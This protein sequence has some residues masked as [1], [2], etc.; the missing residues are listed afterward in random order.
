MAQK[1][2]PL[3][4]SSETPCGRYRGR[5][6]DHDRIT[7]RLPEAAGSAGTKEPFGGRRASQHRWVRKHL[8]VGTSGRAEGAERSA[9]TESELQ[10][11]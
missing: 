11:K 6:A 9:G 8:P 10:R 5:R 1:S 4:W 7:G 2:A 3:R